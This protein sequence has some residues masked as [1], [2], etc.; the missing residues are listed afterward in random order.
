MHR[1]R[2][3]TLSALGTAALAGCSSRTNGTD[4]SGTDGTATPTPDPTTTDGGPPSTTDAPVTVT[5]VTVQHSLRYLTA[6]DAL[7]VSAP[8]DEQFVFVTLAPAD[9]ATGAP[10]PRAGFSL[11]LDGETYAPLDAFEGMPLYE[12]RAGPYPWNA[13]DDDP[14]GWLLFRVPT[15]LDVESAAVEVATGQGRDSWPL[16]A[17]QLTRLTA[18]PP[19]FALSGFSLPKR[20]HHDTPVEYSF[21][22]ANEGDGPGTFRA[23]LNFSGTLYGASTIDV[24]LAAGE[25][26]TYRDTF[27]VY[28]EPGD[29]MGVEL[30]TGGVADRQWTV[31]VVGDGTATPDDHTTTATAASDA[32]ATDSDS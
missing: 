10:P 19:S 9:G 8:D 22:V 3:L 4:A 31:T 27:R 5:D 2:F 13:D 12:V 30:V 14:T 11:A 28:G 32:T 24:S 18:P 1:R 15:D 6:P 25:A 16:P 21:T 29:E 17:D 20:G 23:A 7:G 26:T